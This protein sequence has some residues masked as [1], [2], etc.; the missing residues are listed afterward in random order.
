MRKN[1][2]RKLAVSAPVFCLLWTC[3]LFASS[4]AGVTLPDTAQ[5]GNTTLLLNGL[6]L[7]TKF[8]VKVYVGG[9]YLTQKSSDAEAI[10][11]SDAPKRIVMHF[12]HGASKNQITDGFN[13]SFEDNAAESKKALQAEI[14]RF[15]AAVEPV[16][17]GDEMA[18]T[19][20]PG[21][22]TTFAINGKDKLTIGGAQFGQMLFSVWLGSKPPNT[23]LKK[24]LLGQ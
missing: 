19:Y 23:A 22:G 11:K 5:V 18:F 13:D 7:R 4:L 15:Y 21:T 16:K 10:I 1:T 6:G 8:M 20:V 9:L 24:G 3:S 14:D 17:D 12:V 2:M